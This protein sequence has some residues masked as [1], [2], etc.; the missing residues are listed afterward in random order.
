MNKERKIILI[1]ILATLLVLAIAILIFYLIYSSGKENT[2]TQANNNNNNSNITTNNNDDTEQTTPTNNNEANPNDSTPSNNEASEEKRVTVY[3]FRGEGCPH[4]EHAIE[5]FQS[6]IDD[7]P[8]LDIIS[9]E[10]WDNKNNEELM[11]AVSEELG[12]EVSISVPLIVIGNNYARRGFSDNTGNLIIQEI[13]NAY[14][15]DNYEDV[16]EKILDNNNF[17][18]TDEIIN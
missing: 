6:I 9:Y 8:Y 10:V 2:D 16:V 15:N 17:N 14:Q 13:E 11:N 5:F 1:G 12:I 3:L 18:V 4:C 7:Y